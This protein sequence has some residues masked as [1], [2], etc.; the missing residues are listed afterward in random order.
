MDATNIVLSIISIVGTMSSILFAFLA[1]RRNNKGDHKQEGK[2]E[3]VLISDVGYIKSSIDRIEKTL[4]KL[5]EKYDDLH[6]RI[7]KIEQKVDDHIKNDSI[8]VKRDK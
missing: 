8:H 3:G 2:N 7:I 6:S 1:F 5:E 4:D